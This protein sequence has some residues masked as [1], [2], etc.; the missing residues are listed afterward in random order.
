MSVGEVGV[1]SKM[2]VSKL[3]SAK[4]FRLWSIYTQS[5]RHADSH[6]A[7]LNAEIPNRAEQVRYRYSRTDTLRAHLQTE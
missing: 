1:E 2:E 7:R 3:L 6:P 5:S 4:R